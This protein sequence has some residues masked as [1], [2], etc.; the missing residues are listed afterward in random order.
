MDK[1]PLD[2]ET[3]V[4]S[5]VDV[6]NTLRARSVCKEWLHKIDNNVALWKIH[7]HRYYDYQEGDSK[8]GH[9]RD[10]HT[11]NALMTAILPEAWLYKDSVVRRCKIIY[12][13][14]TM[15]EHP[16]SPLG[17]LAISALPL[18][19]IDVTWWTDVVKAKP[20]INL[21]KATQLYIPPNIAHD[22][23][24]IK[25]ITKMYFVP[26]EDIPD[27]NYYVP[28]KL[29]VCHLVR[30]LL[31]EKDP[32]IRDMNDIENLKTIHSLKLKNV[33]ITMLYERLTQRWFEHKIDKEAWRMRMD[34]VDI[35]S[36][37]MRKLTADDAKHSFDAEQTTTPVTSVDT[38][39]VPL[40]KEQMLQHM[41]DGATTS[42]DLASGARVVVP[43]TT[44]KKI[45]AQ[46]IY[47]TT[48]AITSFSRPTAPYDLRKIAA[49]LKPEYAPLITRNDHYLVYKDEKSGLAVTV[50]TKLSAIK[51]TV[52]GDASEE[53]VA[54][55]RDA[56][57]SRIKSIDGAINPV[58]IEEAEVCTKRSSS[59]SDAPPLSKRR[60]CIKYKNTEDVPAPPKR[61][62]RYSQRISDKIDLDKVSTMFTATLVHNKH[63][64]KLVNVNVKV[65]Y[66]LTEARVL[67]FAD[68]KITVVEADS[69]D[70]A[71]TI[72]ANVLNTIDSCRIKNKKRKTS[73]EH[74]LHRN[75]NNND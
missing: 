14:R 51:V 61:I 45:D 62:Y 5:F 3:V 24:D 35:V 38:T 9:I 16:H 42:I 22:Y 27:P 71:K 12:V 10:D 49:V 30:V 70:R 59:D 33:L 39:P 50:K 15:I 57:V 64:D 56:V 65:P 54:L 7:Y 11:K 60:G 75:D 28:W 8:Y 18:P 73:Q 23:Q 44:T 74:K 47:T 19:H 31:K 2:L 66:G 46:C 40:S 67:I 32:R 37:L 72:W 6:A 52:R 34:E 4:W 53:E 26:L 48:S 68:G 63:N 1:L 69:M 25:D 41:C 55:V 43:T 29:F 20:S 21:A 36:D 58:D 17:T 13:A